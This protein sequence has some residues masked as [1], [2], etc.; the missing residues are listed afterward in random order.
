MGEPLPAEGSTPLVSVVLP[1]MDRPQL[2]RRAIRSIL[3]QTYS[4]FEAFVVDS[5][6]SSNAALVDSFADP[7]LSYVRSPPRGVNAARNIGIR[8]SKGRYIALLD[9]DDEW[10]PEKLKRQVAFLKGTGAVVAGAFAS[11]MKVNPAKRT[12]KLVRIWEQGSLIG[13]HSV[14]P[15]S[16]TLVKREV[17]DNIGLFDEEMPGA[18]D[19]EMWLKVSEKYRWASVPAVLMNYYITPGGLSSSAYR[20]IRGHQLML[21]K[22]PYLLESRRFM[23]HYYSIV[24]QALCRRGYMGKGRRYL[25]HSHMANRGL[26]PLVLFLMGT[27][28]SGAYNFAFSA[29]RHTKISHRLEKIV[30]RTG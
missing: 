17:F 23:A 9:D 19:W 13:P 14:G 20:Q 18:D 8:L 30:E 2:L 1:T 6:A 26:Y 27:L 22:H 7:R 5:S 11:Y 21:E 24:G 10:L 12:A 29:L 25:L 16:V 3:N 4:N 15:A 28:G